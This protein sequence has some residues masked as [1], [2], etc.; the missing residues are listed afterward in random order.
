MDGNRDGRPCERQWCNRSERVLAINASQDHIQTNFGF[1]MIDLDRRISERYLKL[2]WLAP[3]IPLVWET[4][5]TAVL[6]LGS[7]ALALLLFRSSRA[8]TLALVYKRTTISL[9]LGLCVGKV[10]AL[11]INPNV[12]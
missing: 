3:L 4:D 9:T 2:V 8:P 12:H 6:W 11:R 10:M 1:A 5:A 7:T